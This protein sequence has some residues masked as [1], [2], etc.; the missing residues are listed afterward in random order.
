[1]ITALLSVPPFHFIIIQYQS[2]EKG[3]AYREGAALPILLG[4]CYRPQTKYRKGSHQLLPVTIP[5]KPIIACP[6]LHP[7]T[8]EY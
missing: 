6:I 7:P 5:C 3:L 8:K 4:R 1:M 2:N